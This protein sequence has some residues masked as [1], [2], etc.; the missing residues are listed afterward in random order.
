MVADAVLIL[1]SSFRKKKG[2][3]SMKKDT[4]TMSRWMVARRRGGCAA[5][6]T[7]LPQTLILARLVFVVEEGFDPSITK[8]YLSKKNV[9]YESTSLLL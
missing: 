1:L 9:E 3:V 6:P 4:T 5:L 7:T 2:C 8:L